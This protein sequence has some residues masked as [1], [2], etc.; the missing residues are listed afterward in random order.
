MNATFNITCM[1]LMTLSLFCCIICLC[2]VGSTS[3]GSE[4]ISR[5][6]E[7]GWEGTCHLMIFG[8]VTANKNFFT[9]PPEATD[10]SWSNKWPSRSFPHLKAVGIG[11]SWILSY[12]FQI[13]G[14]HL[15]I[16]IVHKPFQCGGRSRM[17]LSLIN[18]KL[19]LICSLSAA[20]RCL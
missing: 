20:S 16:E 13:A 10:G 14:L 17:E 4:L 1:H 12:I 19:V 8:P 18:F 5:K 6:V 15:Q 2:N 3:T 11:A 9:N 7:L